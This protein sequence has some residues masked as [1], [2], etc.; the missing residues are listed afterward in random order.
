MNHASPFQ[1]LM[2]EIK[3]DVRVLQQKGHFG[4]G[5]VLFLFSWT[6]AVG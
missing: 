1:L 2:A 3:L 5:A 6:I 4:D